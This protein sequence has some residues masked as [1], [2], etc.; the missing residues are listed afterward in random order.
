MMVCKIKL[1]KKLILLLVYLEF[2]MSCLQLV[3][4]KKILVFEEDLSLIR[5]LR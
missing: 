3:N 5:G 2:R 4:L 1:K